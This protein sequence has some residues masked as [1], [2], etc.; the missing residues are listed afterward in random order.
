[1]PAEALSSSSTFVHVPCPLA[2]GID[3]AIPLG[4]LKHLVTLFRPEAPF[5]VEHDYDALISNCSRRVG[6][7][8][9]LYPL[10][11]RV[12]TCVLEQVIDRIFRIVSA[13]FPVVAEKAHVAEWWV[14]SRVHSSGHQLHFDSD[15]T[16]IEDGGGKVP[17]HPIASCVL[18][19]SA[20]VGGPTIVTDQLLSDDQLANQG[21]LFYGQ[22]NRLVMFDAK[23]LHGMCIDKNNF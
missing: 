16:S 22:E 3:N 23:Y 4:E 2:Y 9:Y 13:K 12:A 8:S 20:D 15:E 21:W 5:W 6:Y 19:L 1:L 17:H 11:A 10:R 14:H 7:F 18:F